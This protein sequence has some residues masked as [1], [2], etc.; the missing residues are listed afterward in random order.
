MGHVHEHHHNEYLE[1]ICTLAICGA[2]GVVTILMWRQGMLNYILAPK[3]H[4]PLL[5]GG[6]AL[7]VLVVLRAVSL[8]AAVGQ[9]AANHNHNHNHAHEHAHDHDHA[10]GHDHCHEHEHGH[11]HA[12]EHEHGHEHA[13]EHEHAHS[14]HD[15]NHD[16]GHDHSWNPL[17]YTLLLLPIVLF[18]LNLPNQ[19]FSAAYAGNQ[20]GAQDLDLGTSGRYVPNTG[21]KLADDQPQVVKVVPDGPADKAGLK[22]GDLIVETAQGTDGQPAKVQSTKGLSTAEVVALLR[23]KPQTKVKVAVQRGEARQECEITRA[24]EVVELQ[25]K[26]LERAAY[27]PASRQFYEGKTGKIVGQFVPTDS[28][29]LFSLTRF[30]MTCCAAD[31]IPLNVVIMLDPQSQE[32]ISGMTALQWVEVTGRIEFRKRMDRDEYAAVL[33]VPSL[34]AVQTVP[35]DPNPFIQ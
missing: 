26:E 12:H 21:L 27:M 2:L 11:E 29:R 8:W 25:F 16:H 20:S 6:I 5:W 14:H 33:V 35:P 31:A 19:G 9:R 22:V 34:K 18:A 28:N 7:L 13:H 3:F 30:K 1:Q 17:R 24:D 32:N 10:C 23:G 15:H 4:Q